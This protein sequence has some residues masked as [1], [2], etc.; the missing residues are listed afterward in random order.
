MSARP[1]YVD[2][3]FESVAAND[4][5]R[6]ALEQAVADL[7][8]T[9]EEL[10]DGGA[11]VTIDSAVICRLVNDAGIKRC[12]NDGCDRWAATVI[13]GD[14][15]PCRRCVAEAARLAAERDRRESEARACAARQERERNAAWRSRAEDIRCVAE[16]ALRDEPPEIED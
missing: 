7:C 15:G 10:I 3:H 11:H 6:R 16:A 2:M 14:A 13:H 8:N 9:Y 1:N 4:R 5:D 12:R